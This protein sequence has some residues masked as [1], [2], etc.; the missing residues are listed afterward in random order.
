[1]NI[2]QAGIDLIKH[3]EGVK[4]K[5]YVCP[6][7]VLTIGVGSTG[8]HVKPGMT[9]TAAEADAMLRKDLRRFEEAVSIM[10]HEPLEQ[11][12]FDA[13]TSLAFN[14]GTSAF[15][16]ST[17]LKKL[18]KGDKAGAQACFHDWRKGGGKVLPGLV[19]RRAAEAKMFAG[20]PWRA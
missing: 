18:N 16:T 14:I 17:L 12:E 6:A 5:A 19:R 8:P 2:S 15:C 11:H 1:M 7:G 13:L 9:I 10:V 3:F 4:L 20:Q